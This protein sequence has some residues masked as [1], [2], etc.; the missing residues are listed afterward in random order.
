M[1]DGQTA[2][3]PIP[4]HDLWPVFVLP[5]D[6]TSTGPT[7]MSFLL[8]KPAG[9]KGFIK[10]VEGHLAS[11]DGKRWRM[12]SVNLCSDLPMPQMEHA[13]QVA[14]RL[15]KFGVNCLRL[16]SMDHRWPN[17]LLMRHRE[18]ETEILP[19]RGA[20][21]RDRQSTRALDPEALARLDYFIACC[22][23]QGVYINMNLNVARRFSE[24]DGVMQGDRIGWGKGAT[25]FD[26]RLIELQKEYARQLLGHRN[27]FTGVCYAK[28]PAI[29]LIEL[30]NENS[31][32]EYWY[33]SSLQGIHP[34][35]NG[36]GWSDI[37]ATYAREL[38]SM[39]NRWLARKYA[40]REEL[41]RAWS[42]D[43]RAFENPVLGSVRRL[44]AEGFGQA[45]AGRF[46]DE[47]DFYGQVERGF[48]LDMQAFLWGELGVQQLILGTSD[49][50]HGWSGLPVM[51]S[52]AALDI[53]DGHV[54][55]AMRWAPHGVLNAPMVDDPDR[56]APAQLSRS[57]VKDKPYIVSE[58]NEPFPNDYAAE[59]IPLMAAYGL[60][61][62]WDGISF[63]DYDGR[64]ATPYWQREEWREARIPSF[65]EIGRDPVKMPQLAQGALTFLRGDVQAARE[66]VERTVTREWAAESVRTQM[67]HTHPYWLAY[68]PGRLALAHRTLLAR[69]DGEAVAPAEGEVALPEGTI[70][71]DTGELAWEQEGGE[72][73]VRIDTPRTQAIIGRAGQGA[74]SHMALALE[75]PFAAV[76]LSS[77]DGQPI[78][79]AA[80]LL[81]VAGGRVANKGM[82]WADDERHTVAAWGEGPT[83]IEPVIARLTLRSLEGA[84]AVTLQ[85]LD[86]SGQPAGAPRPFAL[87]ADGFAIAL[88]GEPA[89][90]WYLVQIER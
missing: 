25:F 4:D 65:F 22:K 13:P 49:H 37:P 67:P 52:D 29:A 76:Q 89:T 42:G 48:F 26:G 11:G 75:T 85:A 77:L 66:T 12:W 33:K 35:A 5:W 90:P 41:E 9:A 62:D 17:G 2:H 68:L 31:L 50:N 87:Q 8:D 59:F 34:E 30:V 21:N 47:R 81:L 23:E 69:F 73:R 84:R 83:V 63:Y 27:P 28:E 86:A 53:V 56:S 36:V 46:Y 14:R 3:H 60:L 24:G 18:Q 38:D 64:W 58:C 20:P 39:W 6:D 1:T 51:E 82:R 78:A 19:V 10:V 61:Q 40:D 88:T 15:A 80:R 45:A 57:A 70:V 7:D 79:R 32:T 74:T 55:W 43:L 54:Y 16:H 71:S 44:A 72:G